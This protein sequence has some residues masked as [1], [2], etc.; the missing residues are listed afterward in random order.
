MRDFI[1]NSLNLLFV[2]QITK[3]VQKTKYLLFVLFKN[4]EQKQITE[5]INGK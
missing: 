4:G 5:Q 3:L 1:G 2:E